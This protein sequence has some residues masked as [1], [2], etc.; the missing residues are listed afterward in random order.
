MTGSV[1]GVLREQ[2]PDILRDWEAHAREIAVLRRLTPSELRDSLPLLLQ[3]IADA[4]DTIAA[5]HPA[6]VEPE[7]AD[8]H[9]HHRLYE[10]VDLGDLVT[11][12]A[13]LRESIVRVLGETGTDALVVVH[14]AIDRAI[15]RSVARFTRTRERAMRALDRISTA[16]L[17][18]T[19]LDELL[20]ALLSALL[21][22]SPSMDTAAV[23]LREGDM[24]RVRAAVGLEREKEIGFKLRIGQGF[25]GTIAATGRPL[26]LR[27]AAIDPL[28]ESPI[29]QRGIRA[30]YGVP[31]VHEGRLVG[32]AH[33]GSRTSFDFSQEDRHLVGIM[34]ARV[35][36]A[37]VQQSLAEEASE[38]RR[39]A[40]KNLADLAAERTRFIQVIDELPV[41][42]YLA[43]A[44]SGR[45]AYGNRAAHELGR[46]V[47]SASVDEYDA[48]NL[49]DL[50]GE[51]LPGERYP[52]ARAIRGEAVV[53]EPGVLPTS[54]GDRVL[55]ISAKPIR[56]PG[57]TVREAVVVSN[58]LTELH[59]VIAERDAR[60]SSECAAREEAEQ[61]SRL[62]EEVLA[63][64]SHDLKNPIG[65]VLLGASAA[66]TALE[67]GDVARA[68][69][70]IQRVRRSAARMDGLVRDL[71]DAARIDARKLPLD[72]EIVPV[73]KLVMDAVDVPV[74]IANERG[75]DLRYE[76]E[77]EAS[78]RCD[79]ARVAQVLANLV[80]NALKFTPRDGHVV[81][82]AREGG[83]D[84]ELWVA[85]DGPGIA[86]DLLPH[87]FDRFWRAPGAEGAGAGLGLYIVKGI[88]EANGGRISIE[89][90]ERHGTTVRFTL[91]RA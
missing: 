57:G 69:E 60:I 44:P 15:A 63:I 8:D 41:A 25:S 55:S 51:K 81:V 26:F 34:A 62:R 88:V 37:I 20:R 16:A 66:E 6:D 56:G 30:L 43:E 52:L 61:A 49:R 3:E 85:D 91:P 82:G 89:S 50:S 23:L 53:G 72:I 1:G 70:A 73:S 27:H 74:P 46:F 11:E 7:T 22:T 45:I 76:L 90:A 19:N 13:L 47:G 71:L 42:V 75:I 59:R 87:V 2:E 21:E 35:T 31:L 80:G 77:T 67:R 18:S 28:V 78:I 68:V 33:V 5:G 58:D 65:S 36:S 12:Y 64:V 79:P 54:R 48:W 38:Q 32:V 24:V 29:L 9:A 40:E 10:G 14:R 86:E 17:A 83:S 4:C 39:R 84:V